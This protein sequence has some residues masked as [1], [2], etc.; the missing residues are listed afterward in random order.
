MIHP[1]KKL[2]KDFEKK[3]SIWTITGERDTHTPDMQQHLYASPP[4]LYQILDAIPSH[5]LLSSNDLTW[6][7][8]HSCFFFFFKCQEM[9]IKQS[10]MDMIVMM[11][12]T[13]LSSSPQLG[14]RISLCYWESERWWGNKSCRE[15][16]WDWET[17]PPMSIESPKMHT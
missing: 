7:L 3:W 5:R 11:H 12:I 15:E 9:N 14:T 13:A 10:Q 16:F 4:R 2:H 1:A 6:A 17:N 8:F